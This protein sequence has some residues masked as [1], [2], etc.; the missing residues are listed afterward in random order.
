M[1]RQLLRLTCCSLVGLWLLVACLPTGQEEATH[2]P[3]VVTSGV[4]TRT[5]AVPA[6][7]AVPATPSGATAAAYL[8]ASGVVVA[9]LWWPAED[10]EVSLQLITP[11]GTT[12]DVGRYRARRDTWLEV[13][14]YLPRR[15][16]RALRSGTWRLRW[17]SSTGATATESL[18]VVQPG[19]VQRW[20]ERSAT[21][22]PATSPTPAPPPTPT[23]TAVPAPRPE[24]AWAL[25]WPDQP[26]VPR[27]CF[28]GYQNIVEV[29]IRNA[30][31]R[32]GDVWRMIV[33]VINPAG[34][35]ADVATITVEANVMTHTQFDLCSLGGT[36]AFVGTWT[37][38]WLDAANPSTVYATVTFEVL[39]VQASAPPVQASADADGDGLSDADEVRIGTDPRNPDTD[40]DGLADGFEVF[41]YGT[42]PTAIDTDGDGTYDGAEYALGSDPYDPCDPN[43]LADNCTF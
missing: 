38:Q 27:D 20:S 23:A 17:T 19:D 16:G 21:A 14:L 22:P 11:D 42:D 7:T 40:G 2:T 15:A 30:T 43:V 32:P 34:D 24:P 31:G 35:A 29:G 4:P 39:P 36:S 18:L 13:P 41:V 26:I 8:S 3:T 12:I 1:R 28:A 33:R 5:Q 25:Y 37:V 9:Q 10:T 6:T